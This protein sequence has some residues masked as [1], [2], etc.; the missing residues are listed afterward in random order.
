MWFAVSVSRSIERTYGSLQRLSC[1]F[2]GR[3]SSI[4]S[5]VDYAL[6]L[7]GGCAFDIFGR[8]H[9]HLRGHPDIDFDLLLQLLAECNAFLHS[10]IRTQF[11]VYFQAVHMTLTAHDQL[12]YERKLRRLQDELLDLA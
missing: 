2:P 12:I 5:F 6:C 9:I 1:D 10:H 11:D 4:G 7:A 8:E 3:R